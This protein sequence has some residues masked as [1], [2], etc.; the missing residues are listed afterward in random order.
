MAEA[1]DCSIQPSHTHTVTWMNITKPASNHSLQCLFTTVYSFLPHHKCII[2]AL[3][4]FV[5][6]VKHAI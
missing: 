4:Q 3:V 1:E 2:T 5:Q 6:T